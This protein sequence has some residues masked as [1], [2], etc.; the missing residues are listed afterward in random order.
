MKEYP[1]ENGIAV[2]LHEIHL[3]PSRLNTQKRHNTNR[4]HR[5]WERRKYGKFL[6]TQT[7][8][9]LEYLQNVMPIDQHA[10][11]HAE[12]APPKFP[13]P[14]QAMARLAVA[15]FN[16][17]K[18]IRRVSGKYKP[19]DFTDDLWERLNEEYNVVK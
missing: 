7:L 3:P 19:Y 18:I 5:Q 9:D 14:Q 12:Y 6:I 15:Y 2:A 11:L 1:T 13:T 16:D 4:H 17:E 10:W 8:R